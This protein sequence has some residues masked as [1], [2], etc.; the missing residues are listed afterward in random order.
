MT[1]VLKTESLF[2]VALLPSEIN[3]GYDFIKYGHRE[4]GYNSSSQFSL[5]F[6]PFILAHVPIL[7]EMRVFVFAPREA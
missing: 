4:N 6:V 1:N 5:K 3:R 7:L 2:R